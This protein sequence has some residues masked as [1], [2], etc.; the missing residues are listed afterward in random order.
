MRAKEWIVIWVLATAG[1]TAT[2][3]K[4]FQAYPGPA[5]PESQV[6]FLDLHSGFRDDS[7]RAVRVDGSQWIQQCPQ[8][9]TTAKLAL[10]CGE[11]GGW[12]GGGLYTSG[13]L[14]LPGEHTVTFMMDPG[15]RITG[16][17][18]TITFTLEAGKKYS[19]HARFQ[20]YACSTT[21]NV[22]HCSG[23]WSVE[24]TEKGAQRNK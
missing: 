11:T 18:Q 23:V 20:S 10:E 2:A 21:Y 4:R 9:K 16:D 5:L 13:I 24:I 3:E 17:P 22:Q 6:A 19:A 1:T 15:G 14:F 7:I 8:G 12:T